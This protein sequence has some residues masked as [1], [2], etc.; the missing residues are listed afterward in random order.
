MVVGIKIKK[1]EAWEKIRDVYNASSETGPRTIK[2]LHALYDTLK[3]KVRKDN[4]DDRVE[5]YKTGG[6]THTPEVTETGT[7][8]LSLLA[9][10]FEPLDSPYD[11]SSAYYENEVVASEDACS[12]PAPEQQRDVGLQASQGTVLATFILEP[13]AASPLPLPPP[14]SSPL[15]SSVQA[16]SFVENPSQNSLPHETPVKKAMKKK[17]AQSTVASRLVDSI[18]QR[19]ISKNELD[20]EIHSRKL[21]ISDIELQLKEEVSKRTIKLMETEQNIKDVELKIKLMEY[22][23]MKQ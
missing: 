21:E 2:Q 11:S 7:K 17:C 13:E 19:K 15:P 6:G 10:Q 5:K 20:L 23:K 4:H 22:E 9:P 1:L 14:P 18:K 12:S 16:S 3:K 8:L